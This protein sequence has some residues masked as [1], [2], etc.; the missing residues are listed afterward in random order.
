MPIVL[1]KEKAKS[2]YGELV[3]NREKGFSER[4]DPFLLEKNHGAPL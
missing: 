1:D 3:R 2:H 4:V